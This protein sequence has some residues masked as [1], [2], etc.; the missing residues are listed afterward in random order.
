[1]QAEIVELAAYRMGK[2]KECLADAQDA[3]EES[4]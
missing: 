2:A 3:F 1:M 4:R